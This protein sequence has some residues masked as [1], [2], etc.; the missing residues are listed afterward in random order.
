MMPG[1]DVDARNITKLSMRTGAEKLSSIQFV[2]TL[3]IVFRTST[4][5]T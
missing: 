2:F 3:K 1:D 5:S 4:L